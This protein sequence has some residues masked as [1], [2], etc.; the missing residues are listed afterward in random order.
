MAAKYVAPDAPVQTTTRDIKHAI[1]IWNRDAGAQVV[2]A[3][4]MPNP[5]KIGGAEALVRFQLRGEE[6]LLRCESQ[7]TYS[8]NLRCCFLALDAMRLNERRGIADTL[9][10][11]YAALP[12]PAKQRDPYE[13]LGV[14]SDMSTD[15]IE[16]LYAIK[17]KRV[18]PDLNRDDPDA[19]KKAA[20]LNDAIE[21]IRK[22]RGL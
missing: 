8:L 1:E 5:T 20:E 9:R 7:R 2:G 13:V 22:D 14:R 18:H 3:W 21:R 6:V 11:A 16:D 17:I 4:D 19:A 12:A 10:Q 15:D